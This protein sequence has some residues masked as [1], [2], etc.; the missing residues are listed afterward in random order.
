[1]YHFLISVW[2]IWCLSITIFVFLFFL[3]INLLLIFCFGD[4]GKDIF[5]RYNRHIG[6]I[7][8]FFYGIRKEIKGTYPF[9]HNKPCIYIVNHK[10]YLDVIIVASIIP[11]KIKY[12][13]KAEVFDWPLVGLLAKYSGQIP[14][15]REDKLSRNNGYNSMKRALE[16]GFSI[17]IFPEGGWKNNGDSKSSNPYSLK[18][19][20]LL[21]EFRNGSFRLSLE[22]SVPIL[23]IVLMNAEDR[24]SDL[25]LKVTPGLINIYV[26]E[27]IYPK[28]FD[29][30][31]LLN[32]FC[33][34]IMYNQLKKYN[35]SLGSKEI[36]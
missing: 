21:Q 9:N 12:L 27:L 4:L 26:G 11:H 31:F 16:E 33:H 24:F 18:E 14:V 17:I 7:L 32:N 3:P 8:L 36:Q 5:V 20:T 28:K 23:P 13:G 19:N 29:D 25:S 34:E 22:S 2:T 1:M 15:K 30:S 35:D 10:S 6:N